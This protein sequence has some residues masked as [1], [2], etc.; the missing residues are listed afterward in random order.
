[1]LQSVL[2]HEPIPGDDLYTSLDERPHERLQLL[3]EIAGR[4]LEYRSAVRDQAQ[5]GQLR[6]VHDELDRLAGELQG[7]AEQFAHLAIRIR[8]LD[9]IVA[10]PA[11]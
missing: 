1:M 7:A 10:H 2:E 3:V 5:T 9:R 6:E 11:G 4:A 8:E